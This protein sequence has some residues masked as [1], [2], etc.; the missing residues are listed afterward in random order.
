MDPS[1]YHDLFKSEAAEILRSLNNLIVELEKKPSSVDVLNEI[2][3]MAHTLKGIAAT[4]NYTEITKLTHEMETGLDVLRKYPSRV[5]QETCTLLFSALDTL[6]RL[7][8]CAGGN[9]SDADNAKLQQLIGELGK[10][11]VIIPSEEESQDGSLCER[12]M[13]RVSNEDK[14]VMAQAVQRGMKAYIFTVALHKDCPMMQARAFVILKTLKDYGEILNEAYTLN[15]VKAAR[16]GRSFVVICMIKND[17]EDVEKEIISIQDVE[18]INVKPVS[19]DQFQGEVAAVKKVGDPDKHRRADS[20]EQNVR[21]SL[22]QLDTIVN[23]VGEL[24]INRTQLETIARS[25]DDMSLTDRLLIANR[26]L[27]ELQSNVMEARLIPMKTVCDYF[28][29]MVRD[30]AVS[31]GKQVKLEIVGDDIGMDRI[32]LDE[33]RDPLVHILRNS[34]DHGI[35]LPAVRQQRGKDPVGLIKIRVSKEKNFVVIEVSDDGKGLDLAVIKKKAV[36][37]GVVT[38]EEVSFLSDQEAAMLITEPGLSTAEKI[39]QISGRGVGMDIVKKKVEL[40]G[41]SFMIDTRSSQGSVFT[42]KLPVNRTIMKALMVKVSGQIYAI[43]IVAIMRIIEGKPGLI[44][45]V[46]GKMFFKENDQE[47]PIIHLGDVFGFK[48]RNKFLKEEKFQNFPVVLV[49]VN[50]KVVG[51]MVDELVNQQEMVIKTLDE[52]LSRVRGVGGA[53][54]LGSG[55]VALVVDVPS[56]VEA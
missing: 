1:K 25:I 32:I 36:S 5:N 26:L 56:L 54:I 31:E 20:V 41:G 48:N 19:T 10:I 16:F 52:R 18:S 39:T 34:V 6:N 51:L 9:I 30:L 22:K 53:T 17:V 35:E 24:V 44:Q 49:Q 45:A 13:L 21:V 47:I 43:P 7:V 23:L 11:S 12:R 28:P 33:I 15:Q 27:S 42:M 29:R 14:D 4:M 3:R 37:L 8:S 38:E 55:K 40:F 50:H 2:F 46:D